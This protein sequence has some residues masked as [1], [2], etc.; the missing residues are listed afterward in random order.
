MHIIGLPCVLYIVLAGTHERN[1]PHIMEHCRLCLESS[2]S[3]ITLSSRI[4]D[5]RTPYTWM[6]LH[7]LLAH[8][9]IISLADMTPALQP[10]VPDTAEL[11]SLVAEA[12][13]P[14]ATPDSA[15]EMIANSNILGLMNS[16]GFLPG[17]IVCWIA[18]IFA[19][20]YGKRL[21]VWIGSVFAIVGALIIGLA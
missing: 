1:P 15:A 12:V 20:H 2:R 17:L 7:A 8:I 13:K 16:S 6:M 3:I 14:W 21:A 4:L 5:Q 9:L 10:L 18:D 11:L 19:H